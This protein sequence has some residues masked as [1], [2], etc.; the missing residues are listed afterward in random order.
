MC[1]SI[2]LSA[3]VNIKANI[4]VN[5]LKPTAGDIQDTVTG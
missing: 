1:E 2:L 3:V 4:P 5:A